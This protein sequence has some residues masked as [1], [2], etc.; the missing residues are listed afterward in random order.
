MAKHGA[1]GYAVLWR[2]EEILLLQGK[3]NQDNLETVISQDFYEDKSVIHTILTTLL[4]EDFIQVKDN[5]ITSKLI[6]AQRNKISRRSSQC[7]E[8]GKISRGVIKVAPK[9]PKVQKKTTK[10]R[11][12]PFKPPTPKEVEDYAKENGYD[13]N[14]VEFVKYYEAG[15]WHDARGN[16]M[17]NWK[18]KCQAVW[19]R[20]DNKI[21]QRGPTRKDI[22]GE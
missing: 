17:I 9:V 21:K 1:V 18:Q 20:K 10:P 2:V 8:A 15:D 7:S 4:S 14:G 6:A 22:F 11:R 5:I 13:V 12:K 16:K 19:F 3:E